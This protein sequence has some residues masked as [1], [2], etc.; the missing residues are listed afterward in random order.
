MAFWK[1]R[2]KQADQSGSGEPDSPAV[3]NS[4]PLQLPEEVLWLLDAPMFI[5]AA[6][7]E[8]FY[9]A[10][11]RLRAGTWLAVVSS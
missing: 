9:A 1:C 3:E 7:V 6:Q 11:R 2:R 4:A 10:P 8:A 5:D